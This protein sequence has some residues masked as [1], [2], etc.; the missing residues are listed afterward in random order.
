MS[1]RGQEGVLRGERQV[2][3]V[4]Q[5]RWGD[6][7]A[8]TGLLSGPYAHRRHDDA[9]SLVAG[10]GVQ[11]SEQLVRVEQCDERRVVHGGSPT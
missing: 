6:A 10:L 2:L 3:D 8:G 5:P 11:A 7:R 4:A 1:V 9:T